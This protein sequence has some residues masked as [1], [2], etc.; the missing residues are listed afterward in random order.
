ME[1]IKPAAIGKETLFYGIG[2]H[3]GFSVPLN[4]KLQFEDYYLEFPQATHIQRRIFTE[5]CLDTGKEE[6]F[7]LDRNQRLP[8]KHSLFD[9]DAIILFHTGGCAQL[10]SDKDSHSLTITYPQTPICALWHTV[11]TQ[12]PF[13]CIEPWCSLPS[14]NNVIKLE[15]K[16]D[17]FCLKEKEERSHSLSILTT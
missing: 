9:N 11:G 10:K 12:A 2:S 8:L 1:K 4:K 14:Q 17:F 16:S 5:D 13:L 15:S 7:L 6:P 3:P